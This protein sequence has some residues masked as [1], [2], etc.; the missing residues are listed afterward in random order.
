MEANGGGRL[1]SFDPHPSIISG[2]YD[3]SVKTALE[4]HPQLSRYV[5]C[6][7]I[8][9]QDPRL[10]NQQWFMDKWNERVPKVGRMGYRKGMAVTFEYWGAYELFNG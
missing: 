1:N 6:L 10:D 2:R 8:D 7:P 3:D 9:R 4:K 5:V